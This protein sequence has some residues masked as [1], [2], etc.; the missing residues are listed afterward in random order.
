MKQKVEQA[1][2][3]IATTNNTRLSKYEPYPKIVKRWSTNGM[4]KNA[5]ERNLPRRKQILL[6]TT[7]KNTKE[8]N[9]PRR[10][11]I[12]L[13]MMERKKEQNKS[14]EKKMNIIV[15]DENEHEG[16]EYCC[17]KYYGYIKIV[18]RCVVKS[19]IDATNAFESTMVNK[20]EV[21]SKE[22]HKL[23]WPKIKLL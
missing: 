22:V 14:T 23:I 11:R 21:L 13:Y 3:E 1:I 9:P 2:I 10:K 18:M 12:L 7:E 5:K 8:T 20:G 6:Y 15:Y 4:G 16:N 19:I 17:S